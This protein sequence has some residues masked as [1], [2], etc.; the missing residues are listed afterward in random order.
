MSSRSEPATTVTSP[1]EASTDLSIG[2]RLGKYEIVRLLGRGGMGTVYE[3]LNTAIGK[4]VAMKF[5]DAATARNKEAVARFQREAETASAVESAHI[6]EI[7]DWGYTDDGLP[8]IVMELLRGEDLGHRIKRCGRLDLPEAVHVVAQ[9]LRG[10]ARAHEA[11]IIHRDLK[12]DN[13]FLVERDDDPSFAKILDFGISKFQR[14]DGTP[15][16]TLTREGVILGTPFYMSPEQAQALP[17]VDGRSDLWSLG[18]ILY[19][20][21]TGRPPH[22]G[23]NYEQVIVSICMNDADDVR[24][25]NPAVP[26]AMA[27][28]I[29]RALRRDRTGRFATAREFLDA[30]KVAAAERAPVAS[31]EARHSPSS[32]SSSSS[33]NADADASGVFRPLTP[34]DEERS[35]RSPLPSGIQPSASGASASS[36]EGAGAELA[37]DGSSGLSKVGWSTSR[38]DVARRERRTFFAVALSSLLAGGLGAFAFTRS[39]ASGSA[40]TQPEACVQFETNVSSARV[41]VE[42]VEVPGRLLKGRRGDVKSVRIEAPDHMPAELEVTLASE[43][44]P[45]HVTLTPLLSVY[46][47]R[48]TN[49][50]GSP[51]SQGS[52]S[53]QGSSDTQALAERSPAPPS[54]SSAA[55]VR[56]APGAIARPVGS[57]GKGK[58]A[59]A[60]PP[61]ALPPAALPPAA[62]PPAALPPI[63]K[64]AD[65]TV[66]K[67]APPPAPPPVPAAPA[68]R[69]VAG[70][71]KLKTE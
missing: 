42:G 60:L 47:P 13:V 41:L 56:V 48:A 45:I 27:R 2:Q 33:S 37:N 5:V 26:E 59:A 14:A 50:A 29:A 38:Q 4:R 8:Y 10:L 7:F 11:G 52:Q 57:N 1:P 34:R 61:A 71:L 22:S 67:P 12:P 18:A 68:A 35:T 31:A 17:D 58:G 28:V 21:L 46:A 51:V 54:V 39:H 43:R 23:S 16:H 9:I 40:A 24:L 20:C 32:S 66:S 69:G 6:V 3:A 30:L 70:E 65:P 15:V 44:E 63:S 64:T 55:A 36:A 49:P 19:E 62:L 25:H 53:A